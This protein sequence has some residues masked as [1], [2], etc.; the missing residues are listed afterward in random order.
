RPE[1]IA[2]REQARKQWLDAELPPAIE[3]TVEAHRQV[4][5]EGI[6]L[7]RRTDF[8]EM[9]RGSVGEARRLGE[10]DT[11]PYY[12]RIADAFEQ[13]AG[14]LGPTEHQIVGPLDQQRLRGRQVA[15]DDF[16]GR[17]RGDEREACRKR[18]ARLQVDHGRSHEVARRT[19]PAPPLPA[20]P[21]G[22]P[23]GYQP[24]ALCDRL[25]RGEPV[26]EVPA[27][28]PGLCD[29][30]DAEWQV[31]RGGAAPRRRRPPVHRATRSPGSRAVT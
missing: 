24:M 1:R 29:E 23:V 19:E 26:D 25:A 10:I 8:A 12:R 6:A 21:L 17:H 7:G 22:L 20:A 5:G 3:L 2:G 28:G 30:L 9:A 31:R 27:G 15:Y 18:I 11:D 14:E 4:A 13:D 16:V